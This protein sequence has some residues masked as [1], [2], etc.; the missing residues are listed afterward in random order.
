[1]KARIPA[2]RPGLLP[3]AILTALLPV[4]AS[5]QA[6]DAADGATTLDRISVTG[7]RIRGV[8]IEN[9]QPILTVSRQDIER[10]GHT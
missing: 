8:E 5:A 7:S 3:A 4:A 2:M 9:Q 1:M 10:S 6:Q